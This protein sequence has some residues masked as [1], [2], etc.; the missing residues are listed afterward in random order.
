LPGETCRVSAPP[1]P[2]PAAFR[3]VPSGT[4]TFAFTDIEGSTPRWERDRPAMQAAVRRHDHLMR[5]AIAEHGGYV[6]KTVGDA[7]CAAFAR[8]AD[9]VAAILA[10]QRTLGVEDFSAVD[11]LRVRAAIHTGTADE[12]DADYFGPAVNRVARLLASAHGGQVLLSGVTADLVRGELP[13]QVTLQD[14]GEHRLRDLARPEYVY[15]LLAPDL[16][17]EFPP[18]RSLD[19]LPNNLPRMPNALVGREAESVEITALLAQNQLVTLVGSGGIG[20]TR[21]ALQVAANLLDG[22]RDGVWLIELAP[23]TSGNYIPSAVAQALG[24]TLTPGGDAV[25]NLAHAL[26]ATRAL[27]IFDNCEHLVEPT[28][29]VIA[30]ILR[31]CPHVRVLATSR[32]GLGIAA[33]ATFRMPSL[34][35]PGDEAGQALGAA[36][37]TRY[38]AIGLFLE[39]ARAADRRFELT[40]ENAPI[41]ADICRRLDGSPL[42]IELAA[43]RVRILSPLQ[44]RARLDERFRV[45]TGGSRDALPRQQTLRALIDWSHDL[46]DE[47]ERTLFRRLGIFVNG[48]SLEGAVAVGGSEGSD[49]VDVLDVLSS[50]LDKSLVLAEPHGD[51]QRYRLLESTRAYASEKLSD[52]GERGAIASRHLTYLRDRFADLGARMERTARETERSEAFATELED[53]RAALDGALSRRDSVDGSALL[54]EIGNAWLTLGLGVEGIA[55]TENFLEA[56]DSGEALL[57]ARLSAALSRML[58]GVSRKIRALEVAV[59]AIAYARE[60]SD[61][62]ALADAL[63]AYAWVN[64]TLARPDD[65]ERALAEA[66]LIQGGSTRL[67]LELLR[68]RAFLSFLRADFEE[69]VRLWERLRKEHRSLGNTYAEQRT[70]LNL[71]E[72]EHGRGQTRRAIALVREI[73]AMRS[74]MNARLESNLRSNLAG[75]LITVGDLSDAAEEARATLRLLAGSADE[76]QVAI[77]LEHLALVFALRGDL[78]C[79]ATLEGY[80]DATFVRYGSERETTERTTHDRLILVLQQQLA[81]NERKRLTAQ[82]AALTSEAAIALALEEHESP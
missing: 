53:L 71:A 66:E 59:A 68:E 27:L 51:S 17:A 18:L 22:S 3:S 42:A 36:E 25:D 80:S 49:E 78:A 72:G 43:S 40:D 44:L 45:L 67:R 47:R 58:S 28:S 48:F 77:S 50:L 13:P 8:P 62:S 10:A 56:L 52:A 15:Q 60:S 2:S 35:V 34:A 19:V 16:P 65:A 7:F 82:G 38:A 69:A 14:L 6:F 74:G 32:Q 12:R 37:A 61:G 33:E 5:A 29:R 30:A 1:E 55:R 20:K 46:L 75:Y 26:K 21:T 24:I 70:T 23:L 11:G 4:I 73:L 9:A 63:G 79:A 39:R 41:I 31:G 57:R 76:S 81:P 54:A 64:L